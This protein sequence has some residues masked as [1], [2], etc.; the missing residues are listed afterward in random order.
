MRDLVRG[1]TQAMKTTEGVGWSVYSGLM[2]TDSTPMERRR[3]LSALLKYT[4]FYNFTFSG[5]I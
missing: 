4:S 1:G 5:N 3:L 2:E